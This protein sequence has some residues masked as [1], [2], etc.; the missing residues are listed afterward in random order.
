MTRDPAS[1]NTSCFKVTGM[2]RVVGNTV[3]LDFSA[4]YGTYGI[5]PNAIT[6][7]NGV[8]DKVSININLTNGGTKALQVTV[9]AEVSSRLGLEE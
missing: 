7:T 3:A 1:N 6:P 4:K 5:D 8:S 9:V 2:Y